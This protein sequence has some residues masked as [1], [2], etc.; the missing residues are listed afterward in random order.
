MAWARTLA[1]A[2]FIM[3]DKSLMAHAMCNIVKPMLIVYTGKNYL[4]LKNCQVV[5]SR[6]LKLELTCQTLQCIFASRKGEGKIRSFP[7]LPL[8]V[9]GMG[10]ARSDLFEACAGGLICYRHERAKRD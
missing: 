6:M 3:S 10:V 5:C 9:N 7:C 1:V 2:K 4:P 8:S